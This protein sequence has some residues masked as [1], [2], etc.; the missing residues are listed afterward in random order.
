MR[1]DPETVKLDFVD[2]RFFGIKPFRAHQETAGGY[3]FH[4]CYGRLLPSRLVNRHMPPSDAFYHREKIG[5]AAGSPD[6]AAHHPQR[7]AG[8]LRRLLENALADDAAHRRRRICSVTPYGV[9]AIVVAI[10]PKREPPRTMRGDPRRSDLVLRPELAVNDDDR[11]HM[12]DDRYA[13]L[14]A[15]HRADEATGVTGTDQLPLSGRGDRGR[16]Q[17]LIA[18][19]RS[20]GGTPVVAPGAVE[21]MAVGAD[22]DGQP[23]GPART[24]PFSVDLRVVDERT[25]ISVAGLGIHADDAHP[26]LG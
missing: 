17:N 5:R 8:T 18:D 10:E 26:R 13:R 14:R 19:K 16:R 7:R 12:T 23:A 1:I 3:P 22:V 4:S 6:L 2:R 9:E 15:G 20:V 25:G 11:A 21:A 24:V